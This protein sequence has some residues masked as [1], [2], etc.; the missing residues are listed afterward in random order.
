M[1]LPSVLD[2]FPSKGH[3]D[4]PNSNEACL[5]LLWEQVEKDAVCAGLS[6]TPLT[7]Y[8]I[9]SMLHAVIALLVSSDL[10]RVHEFLYRVDLPE[11]SVFSEPLNHED[12]TSL[13]WRI[14]QREALKVTMRLRYST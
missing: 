13:A 9:Q 10:N 3:A 2:L 5:R 11:E 12:E 1:T 8:S 7:N 6:M 4:L 14:L